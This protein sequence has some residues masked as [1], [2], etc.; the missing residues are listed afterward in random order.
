MIYKNRLWQ[1]SFGLLMINVV[2][3]SFAMY[4][5]FST[6][7]IAKNKTA[8]GSSEVLGVNSVAPT[9]SPSFVMSDD[10][11]RSTRVFNS[12]DSIQRYLERTNSPLKSYT[13][14][15]QRASYWIWGASS[16]STSTK[17]GIKPNINPAVII[18]FL[19]KEQSL[20]SLKDYNVNTDP[21]KR[22][23]SAMGYGCPDNSKCSETYW[24]F[25]NQVNWGAYQLELNFLQAPTSGGGTQYKTLSTITTLDGYNVLLGNNATAS[26]YRYTPHVYWGNYNLWKIIT[27]NGW[28]IDPNT[29]SFKALDDQNIKGKNIQLYDG[30]NDGI[31]F[32]E[33]ESLV[34]TKFN[35]G[36][37]S[38]QIR[39]LQQYLRQVGYFPNRE[40]TGFY[41]TI[42]QGAQEA[43]AKDKNITIGGAKNAEGG[44]SQTSSQCQTLLS[45]QWQKDVFYGE[46]GK[47]LQQ[48]LRDLGVFNWPTNTGLFGDVTSRALT[49]GRSKLNLAPQG[50]STSNNCES[51][52]SRTWKFGESNSEV[53]QLQSCMRKDGAFNWPNG[54][55]GYF[56]DA[57]QSAFNSWGNKNIKA[58]QSTDCNGLKSKSYSLGQ[59]GSDIVALQGCMRKDGAFN[60]P[61]GD[62]GY[63]GPVSAEA[64]ASWT[65]KTFSASFSC[66]DLKQQTW[67]KDE[68]SSRVKALQG[69]MRKEGVFNWAAGDT[70]YFGA[71][72]EKSLVSWR[73]YL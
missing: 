68:T 67:I 48:C 11:F 60:W 42:T 64:F 50:S 34:K 58:S 53:K 22:I 66:N 32:L 57:T 55:T 36:D 3:A 52:K 72:T 21:E 44:N 10:T 19:E 49:E 56:G 65:G 46:D 28:G 27:A 12:E 43:Y 45:R 14:N 38:E 8:Q 9:F 23:R 7:N 15:G 73:G 16:G 4:S 37:Q 2:I 63:Y 51:L 39:L 59:S 70:G 71:A 20:I 33:V 24:G 41:G 13:D 40:L 54:D 29:Y 17:F 47:N 18:A 31:E 35:L 5:Y 1:L 30:S 25:A 62:T 69:C 26:V 6:T 61:K